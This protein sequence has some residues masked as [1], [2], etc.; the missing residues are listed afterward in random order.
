MR[1]AAE[2]YVEGMTK[3]YQLGATRVQSL[4]DKGNPIR[5][6]ER[7]ALY[8]AGTDTDPHEVD[9]AAECPVLIVD[10]LPGE[11]QILLNASDQVRIEGYFRCWV[12]PA[13]RVPL[14][15]AFNVDG[16]AGVD[17]HDPKFLE[18]GG[19][20]LDA[21][22]QLDRGRLS[23]LNKEERSVLECFVVDLRKGFTS[24]GAGGADRKQRPAEFLYQVF[25]NKHGWRK[26]TKKAELS[27]SF[28]GLCERAEGSSQ[29]A[30]RLGFELEVPRKAMPRDFLPDTLTNQ[31]FSEIGDDWPDHVVFRQGPRGWPGEGDHERPY[32]RPGNRLPAETYLLGCEGPSNRVAAALW[33]CWVDDH[34]RH[35]ETVR[36]GQPRSFIP[37]LESTAAPDAGE[38]GGWHMVW[39][40]QAI[41]ASENQAELSLDGGFLGLRSASRRRLDFSLPRLRN[42]RGEIPRVQTWVEGAWSTHPCGDDDEKRQGPWRH[43]YRIRQFPGLAMEIRDPVL[44]PTEWDGRPLEVDQKRLRV[45]SLDLELNH[46]DRTLDISEDRRPGVRLLLA[47]RAAS[48]CEACPS[49]GLA[50]QHPIQGT[51]IEL[52]FSVGSVGPGGQDGAV[53]PFPIDC[54][55]P[56]ERKRGRVDWKTKDEEIDCGFHRERPLVIPGPWLAPGAGGDT[57]PQPLILEVGES[58]DPIRG[59]TL[60]MR[61]S[62]EGGT[63]GSPIL[64]D[65]CDTDKKLDRVL[66]L[67]PDPFFAASVLYEPLGSL[68]DASKD[69]GI[70]TWRNRGPEAGTWHLYL[71]SRQGFCLTLPSQG[72][73]ETME[74]Y[75]T[76]GDERADFRLGPPARLSMRATYFEQNFPEAPWNLRRLLTRPGRD[77]PGAELEAAHLELLYGLSCHM[78]LDHMV[79]L[80]EFTTLV[81]AVP[82]PLE[83]GA[84]SSANA[85]W[86]RRF[87]D[88]EEQEAYDRYRAYWSRF[89]SQLAARLAV[90]EV[91]DPA[92][93]EALRQR[94]GVSCWIR[95]PEGF[96]DVPAKTPEELKT[97]PRADL[98]HPIDA[99]GQ[100]VAGSGPNAPHP[101]DNCPPDELCGG[102]TWGFESRNV[103]DA[104]VWP[105]RG[106]WPRSTAAEL[107]DLRLSALGAWGHQMA[108]FDNGLTTFYGDVSMG[109]TFAYRI[110]RIGRIGVFWHRAKHVIVYER[111]VVPSRQFQNDQNPLGGRPVLR[112]VREFVE[113]LE[114]ERSYPDSGGGTSR[115]LGFIRRMTFATQA[116]EVVRFHVKS[117]WG[118]DLDW[119]RA[120]GEDGSAETVE[121][122]GWKV[123]IWIQG[124]EPADVFPRPRIR[125][126]VASVI[127]GETQDVERYID[128]PENLYFFTRTTDGTGDPQAADTNA[129]PPVPGV[130][131]VDRPRPSVQPDAAFLT[132]RLKQTQPSDRL[133]PGGHGVTTFLL[134]P[135][136][137]GAD[138]TVHRPG[139]S[140]S[141]RIR[142]FTMSRSRRAA[143]G[144]EPFDDPIRVIGNAFG[145]VLDRLPK[146]GELGQKHKEAVIAALTEVETKAQKAQK[147]IADAKQSVQGTWNEWTSKDLVEEARLAAEK[148]LDRELK[149][150]LGKDGGSELEKA[151]RPLVRKLLEEKQGGA[152]E[153]AI[154]KLAHDEVERLV[155]DLTVKITLLTPSPLALSSRVL[156]AGR[157]AVADLERIVKEGGELE[158]QAQA[159]ADE[160]LAAPDRLERQIRSWL[161]RIDG[162]LNGVVEAAESGR[163][164]A[165]QGQSQLEKVPLPGIGRKILAS[166]RADLV[167][168]AK[169]ARKA[170]DA[171]RE[172]AV[173]TKA[174]LNAEG[175]IASKELEDLKQRLTELVLGPLKSASQGLGAF[176][177]AVKD[178]QG[179]VH[180]IE[181][182]IEDLEKAKLEEIE[183]LGDRLEK[184]G[185]ETV[186]DIIDGTIDRL[187]QINKAVGDW[188]AP[189][190]E[191]IDGI[192]EVVRVKAMALEA[193]TKK[194]FGPEIAKVEGALGQIGQQAAKLKGQLETL[195]DDVRRQLERERDSLLAGLE[196][197]YGEE[198]R[199][200]RR[201]KG[202]VD[203][204]AE[205]G[206]RLIRAFGE[207]P[208]VKGLQFDRPE[209]A[210]I[211]GE[212]DERVGITPV[213]GRV[214]QAAN[215][216]RAV[217]DVLEPMGIDLPV[218][219][220]GEQLIPENLK[221]FQLS[222]IL[223]DI[224]G[225]RLDKLFSGV[226]M[227]DTGDNVKVRHGID[228]KT[229]RA[230][231]NAELDA[232]IDDN[233]TIFATGPLELAI[234]KPRF[235]GKVDAQID[236][237]GQVQRTVDG[238]LF[239]DWQMTIG[240]Q[241]VLIIR[242][243]KLEFDESGDLR[244]RIRPEQ[245]EL[246]EAMKFVSD[247]LQSI[248]PDVDGLTIKI[249]PTGISSVLMLPLPD[250]QA[251]TSGISGL[252]LGATLALRWADTDP[253]GRSGFSIGLAFNLAHP[254][255]PFAL[256]IFILGGGGYLTVESKY[257]PTTGLVSTEVR[258]AIT[259]SASLAISLGPISGGVFVY[260]GMTTAYSAGNG[261]IDIGV[262]ILIVGRVSV[263]GI[264]SASVSLGLEVVYRN[265][266]LVG[267]GFVSLTIKICWCFTLKVRKSVTYKL[268]GGG[269][270]SGNGRLGPSPVRGTRAVTRLAQAGGGLPKLGTG[271]EKPE[272]NVPEPALIRERV[273]RHLASLA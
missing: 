212:L 186:D 257:F 226:N 26:S 7:I 168:K 240:G 46:G 163:R 203:A 272:L 129:W 90:F 159:T 211:Y 232:V 230:F 122:S 54:R 152:T 10:P 139:E 39:L 56:D 201:L 64:E 66:V 189:A 244:F 118:D 55:P 178:L 237:S 267:R 94:K 223:P 108:A 50:D 88:R 36:D 72:V 60:D 105:T 225:L 121:E 255:R 42:H 222:D 47:P 184:A 227:P 3:P 101:P 119:D 149:R 148:G 263:L 166:V 173:R 268:G 245:V 162:L 251:G 11:T 258:M 138:L 107:S 259:A 124:A 76:L 234:V 100:P 86:L 95:T 206:L 164:V 133:V 29:V 58:R 1:I 172:L 30:F 116:D 126:T 89:W 202:K 197:E 269:G 192:Q 145:D 18:V 246:T 132:G 247:L 175:K 15:L 12:A 254:E 207:P 44:Q 174:Q 85:E 218:K 141:G 74:R 31:D 52:Y 8:D 180:K 114:N 248:S 157:R 23:R 249:E 221:S 169:Q 81:G 109:R 252:S 16:I 67:D 196:Q 271:L 2:V 143:S 20:R 262:I 136:P 142:S 84:R 179:E 9:F 265:K 5:K 233:A 104:T 125:V 229:R 182:A 228:P 264:V 61:L 210:F 45:G 205:P 242:Q 73:G 37:R 273:R 32:G 204:V 154:R 4:P 49:G 93:F 123:P 82:G 260:F 69:T 48:D 191:W 19:F 99:L 127:D 113:I 106:E 62:K 35:A 181:V 155:A 236:T 153:D 160:V 53:D 208:E 261:A 75:K 140:M 216:A 41:P 96:H 128:N 92:R 83:R 150:W 102:I 34:L 80:A 97:L 87:R 117:A 213:I 78:E 33:N 165:V 131:Y 38:D 22:G 51:E 14:K 146:T 238:E 70:A 256:T 185:K 77:L 103:F 239:G 253:K 43:L 65:V 112:K 188:L 98:A 13:S 40:G 250:M 130:D 176:E 151:L 241:L 115:Q 170:A 219:E 24:A 217:G 28:I 91:W 68:E 57:D 195:G 209:T 63:N 177:G 190:Q 71:P 215:V 135:S 220:L 21:T 194:R 6:V 167:E 183:K 193:E 25:P 137:H 270:A 144:P 243:T 200:L 17:E 110:E 266:Q 59:S 27:V 235:Y 187:D 199:T 120:T 231:F 214:A 171:L 134:E 111:S 158:R 147:Q 156:A 79:R 198:L 224:A 161:A